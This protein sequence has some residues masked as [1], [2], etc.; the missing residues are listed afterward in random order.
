MANPGIKR[1]LLFIFLLFTT[2]FLFASLLLF[3][4]QII[5]GRDY[6]TIVDEELYK[7]KS[8]LLAERGVIYDR[9]GTIL[10]FSE[11]VGVFYKGRGKLRGSPLKKST[12]FILEHFPEL[13][14]SIFSLLTDEKREVL[15]VVGFEKGVNLAY[16]LAKETLTPYFGVREDI[17]R[18]YPFPYFANILGR[19][20]EDTSKKGLW[21]LEKVYDNYL[22][23]EDGFIVYQRDAWGNISPYPSYPRKEPKNGCDVYLTLD[24]DIMEISY[25]ELK[26]GVEEFQAKRGAVVILDCS[27]G[28]VLAI[29]DYP[30][31]C[32][33]ARSLRP[34]ALLWEFEPGS[35]FKLLIACAC[36]ESK[37]CN[38]F[39]SQK[40]DVS[41]GAVE[42]GKWTIRE[43]HNK[44][45]GV[46]DF[47]DIIAYSSNCGV[48]H[49][50]FLLPPRDYYS[51]LLDFGIGCPTGI[52]LEERKGYVPAL[53]RIK[54][55]KEVP[56]ILYATN[57]FGQGLRVTLMQLACAYLAIACEGNLLRPYLVKEIRRGDK[58]L[59]RGERLVGRR[60]ISQKS[61]Q[62]MKEILALVCE[63]GT[64]KNAR[65]TGEVTYG[66]TGTA[67]KPYRGVY[68]NKNVNTF[69]GFFPKEPKFLIAVMLDE[70]KG[71]AAENAAVVFKRIGERIWSMSKYAGFLT[72]M[73]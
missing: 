64:G 41:S 26:R 73:K 28:E 51:S 18:R 36:L 39:L 11:I 58:V 37:D 17:S 71:A 6:R 13:R 16:A 22:K 35:V 54:E 34:Y 68:T 5:Q 33:E 66:K 2:G 65:I 20:S 15:K 38:N 57:T 30:L 4:F 45:Y 24:K 31:W 42:I 7:K 69:V 48:T 67:Q 40:Y 32:E 63:K 1:R 47:A 70:P 59:R 43:Y 29:A 25:E 61:A 53:E 50:S 52:E 46:I 60:A 19:V 44:K 72:T 21:G 27:S 14:D 62:K 10:A 8:K 56:V 12:R 3:N 55:N 49:L 23:G 9:K